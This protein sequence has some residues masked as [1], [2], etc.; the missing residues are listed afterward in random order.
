MEWMVLNNIC[1]EPE[2]CEHP[3]FFSMMV[4]SLLQAKRTLPAFCT[5]RYRS[6]FAL[7]QGVGGTARESAARDRIK[8]ARKP[9]NI[10]KRMKHMPPEGIMLFLIGLFASFLGTLAGGGGLITIP[11]MML[12][13]L[14]V[15][16]GVATNKFSSGIASF[17]SVVTLLRK[18]ALTLKQTLRYVCIALSGG[19]VGALFSS[20]LKEETMNR[21]AIVLLILV[22]LISMRK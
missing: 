6:R 3:H 15:Q 16:I 2:V 5:D 13:G 12:F 22:L 9:E 4:S 19:V 18:S 8:H 14:P 11:A 21:V 7:L 10:S 20:H 17:S 1:N